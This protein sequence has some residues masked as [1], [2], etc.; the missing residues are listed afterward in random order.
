MESQQILNNY[1]SAITQ[2]LGLTANEEK[3]LLTLLGAA[4]L[5]VTDI[6]RLTKLNRTTIYGILETLIAG[7]LVTSFE[8]RGKILEYQSL[9][10]HQLIEHIERKRTQLASAADELRKQLPHLI[11]ERTGA[12]GYPKTQFFQGIEGVKEAYEDSLVNNKGK[13]IYDISGTDAVYQRM[14]E[15]WVHYYISKRRDLGIDCQ[16]IAPDTE[17]SHK[18][19][20]IDKYFRRVTK[21]MPKEF[22]F[23]TEVDIWDNKVGLFTFTEENPI[24]VLIEDERVANTMRQMFKYIYSTLDG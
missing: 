22:G 8:R 5:R 6:A 3:V 7:G 24:A 9:D 20:E 13:I 15:D 14:G 2:Q 1:L 23:D 19:K 12:G 17:W 21:L 18:S 16:V 4:S 10:P 11:K